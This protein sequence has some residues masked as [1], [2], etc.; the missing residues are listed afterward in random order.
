MA[1]VCTSLANFLE[2]YGYTIDISEP[3]RESL[4]PGANFVVRFVGDDA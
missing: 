1:W 2:R 3:L 4:L